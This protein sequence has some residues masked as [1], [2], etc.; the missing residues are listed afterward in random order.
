VEK[1]RLWVRI[2]HAVIEKVIAGDLKINA[3]ETCNYIRS[4]I[5]CI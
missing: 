3:G 4:H 5:Q 2:A 1:L